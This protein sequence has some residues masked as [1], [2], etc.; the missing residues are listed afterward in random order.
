MRHCSSRFS[1]RS[2][3]GARTA[4]RECRRVRIERKGWD[5][6]GTR[7]RCH[8]Q[9]LSKF[10]VFGYEEGCVWGAKLPIRSGPSLLLFLSITFLVRMAQYF[11]RFEQ[12]FPQ[13]AVLP[14]SFF[15]NRLEQ[16]PLLD[17]RLLEEQLARPLV[18][19]SMSTA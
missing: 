11:K 16:P 10:S 1:H 14:G 2:L 7:R 15:D 19:R 8:S 9:I 17:G 4:R 12:G 18:S 5:L 13:R 6:P 3:L